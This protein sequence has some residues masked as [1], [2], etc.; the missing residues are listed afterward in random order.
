VASYSKQY[1]PSW[2]GFVGIH[3]VT[4]GVR[5]SVA[6]KAQC[7]KPKVTGARPDEVN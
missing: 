2:S 4:W 5:G 7:Y 6:V 1:T 3:A